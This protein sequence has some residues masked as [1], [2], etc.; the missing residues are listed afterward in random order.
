MH[1]RRALNR[2]FCSSLCT[3]GE[4]ENATGA[5]FLTVQGGG[6]FRKALP[7]RG[8]RPYFTE[9]SRKYSGA[10]AKR[11][12]GITMSIVLLGDRGVSDA[13]VRYMFFIIESGRDGR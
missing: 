13:C 9:L 10:F 5:R 8:A 6:R 3:Y 7:Y 12:F 2:D 4:R 1:L 11:S